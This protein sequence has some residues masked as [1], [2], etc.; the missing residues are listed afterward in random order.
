MSVAYTTGGLSTAEATNNNFVSYYNAIKPEKDNKLTQR[1]GNQLLTGLL[2]FVGNTKATP[3]P[4]YSH[5]EERRYMPLIKATNAG[6]G[7]ANAAVTFTLDASAQA[8]IPQNF[9]P[10][11][12]GSTATKNG[13]PVI[14]GMVIM[15][16]PATAPVDATT[17]TKAIV[18]AVDES[19]GT[20]VASPIVAGENIPSV[21][22]ADE[23]VVFTN[24]H[25]DG[26][27]QPESL[28]TGV[29]EYTNN[30]QNFRGVY[31]IN[32][33]MRNT[34]T[35]FTTTNPQ[36]GE[37]EELWYYKGEKEA[38]FRMLN[39]KELGMLLSENLSN[40]TL[41][42]SLEVSSGPTK[43]TEGLI[44]F[45]TTQGNI[46]NYSSVSGL[47]YEDMEN[48]TLVLDKQ[49]GSRD[50]MIQAGIRLSLQIDREFA[51]YLNNGAIT[52]GNFTFDQDMK[53]NFKFSDYKIGE[54]MFNKHTYAPFN[55]RHTLGADGFNFPWEGIV[56]P[57]DSQ[58]DP[59]TGDAIP[60]LRLRYLASSDES[61][62]MEIVYWDGLK[63]GDN[64]QDREEVRYISE[65]GFEGMAG[66][67]WTYIKKAS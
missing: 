37:K 40:I 67:R 42:D 51:G 57:M 8:A 54:Y 25:A 11:P 29:D 65:C 60:S 47:T 62:Q 23:I 16:K 6:A 48:I 52:Y 46:Q 38:M 4:V 26:G 7:A 1:Y 39:Y 34:K 55:D 56:I 27:E 21:A 63:Q 58:P 19:A 3:N 10:F 36:N 28:D 61:R 45:V 17:Y 59:K 49:K 64:G 50:N 14:K 31:G 20:F 24:A 44:P 43:M 35:W 41:Y 53:V 66:N 22:S 2:E 30:T 13:V 9:E 5:F 15:I 33:T 12:T 32:K 18:T